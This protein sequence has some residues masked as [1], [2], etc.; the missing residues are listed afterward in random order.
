MSE[1]RNLWE[2]LSMEDLGDD[3][4]AFADE[5]FEEFPSFPADSDSGTPVPVRVETQQ[6]TLL[7]QI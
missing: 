3:A 2:R 7:F 5:E 1:D 6:L 4:D